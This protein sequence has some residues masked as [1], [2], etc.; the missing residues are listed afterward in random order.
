M[1]DNASP[2]VLETMEAAANIY[3]DNTI[4]P[5]GGKLIVG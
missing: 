1:D 2:K 5:D 4:T 3:V